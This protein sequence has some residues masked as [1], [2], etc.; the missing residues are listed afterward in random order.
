MLR[1]RALL[2]VSILLPSVGVAQAVSYDMGSFIQR[3]NALETR[4]QTLE[5]RRSSTGSTYAGA[6]P[7][8]SAVA[9]LEQRMEGLE[10]E[11]SRQT[12]DVE[13]LSN[14]ITQLAR[15][16]E[17]ISKDFDMRLQQLENAK[18]AADTATPDAVPAAGESAPPAASNIPTTLTATEVYNRAYGYLTAANYPAA[19]E[20]LTTFLQR[21]PKDQLADNAHYWLGEVYMVQ[22][23]PKEAV[24]SF[25]NGLQAFPKGNK[26]P[27]NLFKMGIA[28]QQMQQP[29]YAKASWEKLVHDYPQNPEADKARQKLKELSA[30]TPSKK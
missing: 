28:L 13:R 18:P 30:A 23:K 22:G 9:D 5:S 1:L 24:V 16:L 7:A 15:R 3:M 20:W 25:R 11:S 10:T 17:A 8:G 27:A 2:L 29:Q 4:L 6:A 26:A 19:Q 14:S 12:G 21:F